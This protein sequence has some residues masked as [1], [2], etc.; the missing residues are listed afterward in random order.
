VS[1][2]LRDGVISEPPDSFGFQVAERSRTQPQ[3]N[4]IQ[5][6]ARALDI[7]LG[8]ARDSST[9]RPIAT[10]TAFSDI[11]TMSPFSQQFAIES[12]ICFRKSS[13]GRQYLVLIGFAIRGKL[14]TVCLKLLG[15]YLAFNFRSAMACDLKVGALIEGRSSYER[16]RRLVFL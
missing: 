6:L 2:P 15:A 1:L 4:L 8:L 9:I 13:P 5:I 7:K 3:T 16:S 11:T 12:T 14:N 10:E